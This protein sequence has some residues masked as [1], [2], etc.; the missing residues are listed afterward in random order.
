[1]CTHVSSGLHWHFEMTLRAI[2]MH[3]YADHFN[4]KMSIE[5]VREN[6]MQIALRLLYRR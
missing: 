2:S 4:A 3:R 5:N 1:M 6:A